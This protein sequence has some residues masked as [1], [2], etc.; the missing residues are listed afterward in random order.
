MDE[1]EGYFF[2]FICDE[3]FTRKGPYVFPNQV[4]EYIYTNIITPEGIA[5]NT[6]AY[7]F[8]GIGNVYLFK[9]SEYDNNV[10]FGLRS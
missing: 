8:R 7:S 4:C 9:N 3:I 1:F 6:I 10:P 2:G 5:S